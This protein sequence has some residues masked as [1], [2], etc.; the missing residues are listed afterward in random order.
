MGYFDAT[1]TQVMTDFQATAASNRREETAA[2]FPEGAAV[3]GLQNTWRSS[4]VSVYRNWLKYMESRKAETF[5][6]D[7]VRP[8]GAVRSIEATREMA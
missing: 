7:S 8:T 2:L 6:V 3:E 1:A 5:S 4:A